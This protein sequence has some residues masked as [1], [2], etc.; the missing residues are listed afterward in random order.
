M[1]S[2]NL[3]MVVII[4]W[5][6]LMGRA[7]NYVDR[8]ETAQELDPESLLKHKKEWSDAFGAGSHLDIEVYSGLDSGQ[9]DSVCPLLI[10]VHD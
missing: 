4:Y 5:F 8:L 7:E 9:Q 2:P 1:L 6:G 3:I 10:T